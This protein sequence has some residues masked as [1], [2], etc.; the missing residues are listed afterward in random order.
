MKNPY[1]FDE[2]KC[3]HPFFEQKKGEIKKIRR[4]RTEKKEIANRQGGGGKDDENAKLEEKLSET[5]VIEIINVKWD[6]IA[7]F[8]K[9]KLT[10]KQSIKFTYSISHQYPLLYEDKCQPWK[11][12]L[13]YWLLG[14][15][16]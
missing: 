3:N 11:V 2:N 6:D 14:A 9:A 13:V 1:I 5:L 12:M 4:N 15:G 8:E 16:I 7:G 10:L